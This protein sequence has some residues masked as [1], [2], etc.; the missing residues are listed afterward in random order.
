MRLGVGL[1]K[2]IVRDLR[3]KL[4]GGDRGMAEEFLDN[5]HVCTMAEHVGGAGVPKHMGTDVSL[6]ASSFRSALDHQMCTLSGQARPSLIQKHCSLITPKPASSHQCLPSLGLQPRAKR[7]LSRTP[8]R[9]DAFF[10]S[11]ANK[12][13]EALVIGEIFKVQRGGL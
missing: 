3:V 13:K 6:N 1:E 11:L 4:R 10:V 7:G 9:D 2:V 8:K 12:A 5:P